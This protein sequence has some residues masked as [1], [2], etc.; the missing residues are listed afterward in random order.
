MSI[1]PGCFIT[2]CTLKPLEPRLETEH[3]TPGT[4][5][6]VS[7]AFQDPTLLTSDTF[8]HLELLNLH[9]FSVHM[10]SEEDLQ[11]LGSPSSLCEGIDLR[12]SGLVAGAFIR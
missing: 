10:D 3:R 9:L 12:F 5:P 7:P 1:Q 6:P 8:D 2:Q 4:L 11:E